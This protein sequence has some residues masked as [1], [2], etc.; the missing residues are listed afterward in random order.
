MTRIWDT[1]HIRFHNP[2]RILS[3]HIH[4]LPFSPNHRYHIPPILSFP[5]IPSLLPLARTTLNPP[6]LLPRAPLSIP[7][8]T[9]RFL[10][11]SPGPKARAASRGHTNLGN[12][13]QVF[14]SFDVDIRTRLAGQLR[15]C[16][17]ADGGD[18]WALDKC[19]GQGTIGYSLVIGV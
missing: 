6:L 13:C 7:L 10:I 14:F 4:A 11:S 18:A 16:C 3:S 2:F 1:S 17:C 9:N 8:L 5:F 19:M 15:L 12:T